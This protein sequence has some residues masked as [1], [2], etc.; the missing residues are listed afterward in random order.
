ML[1]L[2][3]FSSDN[4]SRP[5]HEVTS[6][7]RLF[8]RYLQS[9]VADCVANG[10]RINVIGRRD[11]LDPSLVR[12]V[13]QTERVT[14]AGTRLTLHLAVDYSARSAIVRAAALCGTANP[15]DEAFAASLARVSHAGAPVP[16]VDLLIRTGGERRLSDFL[17]WECAYAELVFVD[18][19]WPDFD[20]TGFTTALSE[21]HRRERRFGSVPASPSGRANALP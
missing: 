3:A 12:I 18:A 10:I 6:L 16:P 13:E 4:W 2:Y 21:F 7:M 17:L 5:R 1:T 9:E 14:A 11:R 8:K 15:S 19:Y 20:E